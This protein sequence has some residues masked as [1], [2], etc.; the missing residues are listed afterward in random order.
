MVQ[1]LGKKLHA[2]SP[3]PMRQLRVSAIGADAFID[4]S[5]EAVRLLQRVV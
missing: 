1:V 4:P 5:L 3:Y 2:C